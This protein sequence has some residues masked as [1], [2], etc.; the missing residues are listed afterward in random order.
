MDMFITSDFWI[1]Y[2]GYYKSL[3][4]WYGKALI[5]HM[6]LTSE[7]QGSHDYGQIGHIHEQE[8]KKHYDFQT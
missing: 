2:F 1:G 3:N 6:V 5:R 4:S 7:M 8:L